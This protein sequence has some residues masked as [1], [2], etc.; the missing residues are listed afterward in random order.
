MKRFKIVRS[1][2]LRICGKL[3]HG[4][5]LYKRLIPFL[6][7][8]IEVKPNFQPYEWYL[9]LEDVHRRISE[10]YAG[11]QVFSIDDIKHFNYIDTNFYTTYK[12]R[13]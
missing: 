13:E 3:I 6:P 4:Y 11:R 10:I 1:A 8:W 9:T 2:D 5:F 7:I 12:K